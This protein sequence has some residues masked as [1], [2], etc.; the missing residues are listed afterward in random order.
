MPKETTINVEQLEKLLE[1]YSNDFIELTG[2][3]VEETTDLFDLLL[4]NI[5]ELNSEEQKEHKGKL[6]APSYRKVLSVF[7][8]ALFV[9]QSLIPEYL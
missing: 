2:G 6:I 3:K 7:P 9:L 5:L 4:T 8:Y 1:S